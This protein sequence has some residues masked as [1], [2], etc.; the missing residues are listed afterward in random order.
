MINDASSQHILTVRGEAAMSECAHAFARELSGNECVLLSGTLGTGKT[1]FARGVIRALC[2]ESID[3]VSPTFMLVQHYDASAEQ[4]SFIIQHYDLYRLQHP[5]ELWELGIEEALGHA[6]V[7]VEWPE[8][9]NGY[10]PADCIEITI[11]HDDANNNRRLHVTAHG[12]MV[13]KMQNFCRQ[14]EAASGK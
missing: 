2:G 14:W 12:S 5:D 3:V 10:W 13:G 11:E 4:G 9:A 1:T 7:L 6:L 8:I